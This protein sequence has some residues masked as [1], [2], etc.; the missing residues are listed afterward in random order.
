MLSVNVMNEIKISDA[1]KKK[2]EME[3]TIADAIYKFTNETGLIVTDMDLEKTYA[4]R[5]V[6][7]SVT[8]SNISVTV[9]V[10]L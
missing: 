6:D 3:K 10:K 2:A 4:R 7:G 1:L 9:N 5:I 8:I